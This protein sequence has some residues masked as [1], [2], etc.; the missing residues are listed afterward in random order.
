MT[1][2]HLL[3]NNKDMGICFPVWLR[4]SYTWKCEGDFKWAEWRTPFL[5][6]PLPNL[7]F[8]LQNKH[9]SLV[10]K[11]VWHIGSAPWKFSDWQV[12]NR[13]CK[14]SFFLEKTNPWTKAEFMLWNWLSSFYGWCS[15]AHFLLQAER[16]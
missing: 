4:K 14:A 10:L 2:V 7:L 1:C 12:Q 13:K 15:P 3:V 11:I 16:G 9:C 6:L 8:F 5:C